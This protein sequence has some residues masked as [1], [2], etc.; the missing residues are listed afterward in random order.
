MYVQKTLAW[1]KA[2]VWHLNLEEV[3]FA[4]VQTHSLVRTVSVVSVEL[5]CIDIF[6]PE[7]N[8]YIVPLTNVGLERVLLV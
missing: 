6:H 2:P 1:T 4:S 5:N 8:D 3:T 7:K